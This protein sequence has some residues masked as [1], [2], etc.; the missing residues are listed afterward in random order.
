MRFSNPQGPQ[1]TVVGVVKDVRERGYTLG[2]KP[3][4]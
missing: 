1:F 3:E 2:M 4:A